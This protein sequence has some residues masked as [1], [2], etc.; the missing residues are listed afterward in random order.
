MLV[1]GAGDKRF[2]EIS[3]ATSVEPNKMYAVHIDTDRVFDWRPGAQRLTLGLESVAPIKAF[4]LY[5]LCT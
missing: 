1:D 3:M 5:I 4:S 2:T